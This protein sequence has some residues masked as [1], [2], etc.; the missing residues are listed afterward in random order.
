MDQIKNSFDKETLIKISK[1]ALIAASGAA[2]L[3]ILAII[4][5]LEIDNPVLTSFF[6]WFIPVAVN[7]IREW[8][9]GV[10]PSQ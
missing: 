2:G 10:T 7:A 6:A 1:G 5:A 8:M 4:G 3:Y 9:K